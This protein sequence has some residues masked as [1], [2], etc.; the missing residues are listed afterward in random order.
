M[1]T[2]VQGVCGPSG[3]SPG[4]GWARA[5]RAQQ[6]IGTRWPRPSIPRAGPPPAR[7]HCSTPGWAHSSPLHREGI[8]AVT[9]AGAPT[10]PG[11]LTARPRL[12]FVLRNGRGHQG[13]QVALMS[14]YS[15]KCSS[16]WE[17]VQGP[18]R[19][20]SQ[21]P[22]HKAK[23]ANQVITPAP[24]HP[25]FLP[26]CSTEWM[27]YPSIL[28]I[29]TKVGNQ[30]AAKGFRETSQRESTGL[31]LMPHN[32]VGPTHGCSLLFSLAS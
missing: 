10:G 9:P 3:S 19:R 1:K 24:A 22:E 32:T 14:P 27:I 26:P 21:N 28:R 6:P 18:Q 17:G 12:S 25:L 4:Y 13:E 31:A 30:Q 7:A 11:T 29:R 8:L 5:P 20:A 16:A 15:G 2:K 23:C